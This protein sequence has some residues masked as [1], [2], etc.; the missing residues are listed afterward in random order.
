MKA[1][2]GSLLT[3]ARQLE[4]LAFIRLRLRILLLLSKMLVWDNQS[5]V[6]RFTN[7]SFGEPKK[8]SQLES[9]QGS[10]NVAYHTLLLLLPQ[11]ARAELGLFLCVLDLISLIKI[12]YG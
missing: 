4:M 1:R 8:S 9:Y 11:F 2:K 7:L 3:N 12:Q 6:N 5:E 10:V